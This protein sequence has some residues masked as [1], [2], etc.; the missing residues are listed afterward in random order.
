MTIAKRLF[1]FVLAALLLVLALRNINGA[2]FLA[3]LARVE[4]L[5]VAAA[6][7]LQVFSYGMRGWRWSLLLSAQAG[8]CGP[9]AIAGE[10]VGY[11]GNN[12]LPARAGEAIR[13]LMVSRR[14]GVGLAF[15]VGTAATERIGDAVVA[16]LCAFIATWGLPQVPAWL[17]GAASLFAAAGLGLLLALV[18]LGP[19]QRL[20][21]PLLER[22][23][24]RAGGLFRRVSGVLDGVSLG[25]NALV[26]HP[27]RS[28]LYAVL[29]VLVWAIDITTFTFLANAL[30]QSLA[31]LQA[32]LFVVSLGLSS[33]IPS[34]PGFVGIFQ[35][36]A[37][38]VL[39][40]FGFTDTSAVALVVLFQGMTLAGLMVLGGIAWA[41]LSPKRKE[42]VSPR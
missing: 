24:P 19:V 22:L 26:S 23:V 12:V 32:M 35:F 27:P 39:V 9:V 3:T 42:A 31:P 5:W 7:V 30:G 2:E 25:A 16:S 20:V 40:P 36:V 41:F 15:V 8:A 14:L 1:P 38:T 4:P 34:T 10:L 13:T 6:F 37:V 33:A 29:T 18:F 11:L 17:T 28:A 21:I